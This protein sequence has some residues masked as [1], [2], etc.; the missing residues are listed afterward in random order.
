VRHATEI[1]ARVGERVASLALEDNS[2]FAQ[3]HLRRKKS[4]WCDCQRGAGLQALPSR[5]DAFLLPGSLK[6]AEYNGEYACR[7]RLYGRRFRK[8]FANCQ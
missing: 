1:L 7:R 5:V 8:S 3:F 6:F 2:L 4:A